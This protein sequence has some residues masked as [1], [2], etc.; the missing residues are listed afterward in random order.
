MMAPLHVT[1]VSAKFWVADPGSVTP[2]ASEYIAVFHRWIQEAMVDGLLIDV[3]DYGHVPDGP[4][5]MLIGHE[6]DRAMD[7]SGGPGFRFE[8][9]RSRGGVTDQLVRALTGAASGA[10]LLA[11]DAALDGVS[12]DT[13]R[14]R[15]GIADR[16]RVPNDDAT[17]A[18]LSGAIGEAIDTVFPDTAGELHRQGD[19][20]RPFTVDVSLSSPASLEQVATPA[21]G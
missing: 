16:L 4:G 10:A 20:R 3:A 17:L 7:L 14:V 8:G 5:V 12:F 18:E 19:R 9:K 1:R 2:L 13:T 15:I 6:A 21:A 11:A